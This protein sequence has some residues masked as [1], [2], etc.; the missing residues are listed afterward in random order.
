MPVEV[1]R[2]QIIK[3]MEEITKEIIKTMIPHA[4]SQ[5]EIIE[6]IM[7]ANPKANK[8]KVSNLVYNEWKEFVINPK[9][10]SLMK[11]SYPEMKI[12]I[13]DILMKKEKEGMIESIEVRVSVIP[14]IKDAESKTYFRAPKEIYNMITTEAERKSQ[15]GIRGGVV[16]IIGIDGRKLHVELNG[17]KSVITL[18]DINKKYPIVINRK[19]T[20]LTIESAE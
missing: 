7:I 10:I 3:I 1:P 13:T 8:A 16:N 17:Q 2:I 5:S 4:K 15:K 14:V 19:L 12:A 11:L 6:A 18:F 20:K 9:S